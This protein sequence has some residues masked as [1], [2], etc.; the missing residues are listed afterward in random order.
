MAHLI[1]FFSNFSFVFHYFT[2]MENYITPLEILSHYF[3]ATFLFMFGTV[4]AESSKFVVFIFRNVLKKTLRYSIFLQGVSKLARHWKS[5]ILNQAIIL[6][7][8]DIK[9][10]LQD[11]WVNQL[12]PLFIRSL[13]FVFNRMHASCSGSTFHFML[14]LLTYFTIV[15]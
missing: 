4:F 14:L 11:R 9:W 6:R 1:W 10:L 7:P 5:I 8:Y 3:H 15:E 2:A 12:Y 13:K